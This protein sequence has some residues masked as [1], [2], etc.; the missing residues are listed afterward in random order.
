MQMQVYNNVMEYRLQK[1]NICYIL[2]LIKFLLPAAA[3]CSHICMFGILS[4]AIRSSLVCSLP[5]IV[6]LAVADCSRNPLPCSSILQVLVATALGQAYCF[7]SP[8]KFLT[9][10]QRTQPV[11]RERGKLAV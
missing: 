5:S 2:Q 4:L 11:L 3:E 7:S 9:N 8:H 6:K 10:L 1:S